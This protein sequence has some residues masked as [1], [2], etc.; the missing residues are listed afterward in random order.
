M[1]TPVIIGV[2]PGGTGAIAAVDAATGALI[3]CEDMPTVDKRVSGAIVADLLVNEV[4]VAAWVEDLHATAP[5]G[6]SA[7]FRMG[8]SLGVVLGTLASARIPTHM[9]RPT[10]WKKAAGLSKD[11]NQSRRLA[12]ELYPDHASL[13]ARVKD[14]GRAESVLIA[15]HGWQHHTER[16]AA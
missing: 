12:L 15:R 13:F 1:N 14:D 16:P 3:W 9:V 2:D 11:K 5:M 10:V 4:A 7:S 8:C 6:A